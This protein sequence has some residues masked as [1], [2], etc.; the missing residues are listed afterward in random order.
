MFKKI[1][2][3]NR[4][5]IACR[6]IKT[7][8]RMG[9]KSV[10]VYSDA[11]KY[12][13]HVRAA[14]E[15]V[16][17][18]AAPAIESYL[19]INNILEAV[20]QTNA[21]AVHPGY[22]FLS[23][24]KE[25]ALAL[26]EKSVEFVG[27]PATAI[28]AM[29]DKI[30]SKKIAAQAGVSIVPGYDGLIESDQMA[31]QVAE[32]IGYP[33]MIKASAGG[34]GKGMRIAWNSDQVQEGYKSSRN[35][36]VS[37][38]GDDRILIERFITGPRHI[39]IQILADKHGNCIYLNERE[40][41]IQ[42]RNQKVIEEA[43]SPFLDQKTRIAMGKQAV[44]LAQSV[45]Y[46]SAGTVEFIV[47]SNGKF[48]FLEMNT[49]LQVEHPV[50][51]LITGIDLVEQMLRIANGE[52][53]SLSQS[54]ISSNGWA[55]ES[56]IYAEDPIRGFLPSVGRLKR[57]SPPQ[58]ISNKTTVIRNDAG[59]YEGGE[60]SVHY[61]PMI[62]KLCSWGKTRGAAIETMC[63]ALDQFFI[64]G[65]NS[66]IPF[67]S[68]V[69]DHPI[70]IAGEATTAFIE[71]EFPTGFSHR[72]LP[73]ATVR[74]LVAGVAT[75]YQNLE[76]RKSQI[77]GALSSHQ[78]HVEDQYVVFVEDQSFTVNLEQIDGQSLVSFED[79][80]HFEV[81]FSWIQPVSSALISVQEDQ[82][83]VTIDMIPNG[84]RVRYRGAD[85]KILVLTLRQA[86]L[87]H[88]MPVNKVANSV[89]Q[90][91]CPMP[92]LIVSVDVSVGDVVEVGQP[93]CTMEAMKMENVLK[94]ER[95]VVVK[96]IIA[97]PGDTLAVDDVILEFE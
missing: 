72:K 28:E 24:N 12:A 48:Y 94:S 51:E 19:S 97:S 42:R 69:M 76:V 91:L 58:E 80:S 89:A 71:N 37:A 78:C 52:K 13:Q 38:F 26:A 54:D 93:L 95:K 49:R 46:Y 74:Q 81:G 21:E 96:S 59:V 45:G 23:E 85:L 31:L 32:E 15:A 68:T 4:G 11:D 29:G 6:V 16:H 60:I 87:L 25:F 61:D 79:Y 75:I 27:P 86:E 33:V 65:I 3:A 10:A 56:R 90:L 64:E 2:I 67:L 8:N 18:G 82:L 40:C 7:A 55:I 50:T 84:M 30:E 36:A 88:Y 5:E 1:L 39:E 9:I 66:N 41:S 57:Y 83:I 63:T 92:G 44:Q 14:D 73:E 35:E 62:S 22:G 70:F 43:P 77:S 17:I 20:R 34:G 47:D 53:L